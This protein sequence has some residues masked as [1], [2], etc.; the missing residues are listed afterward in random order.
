MY[1]DF[2]FNPL[3]VSIHLYIQLTE[4]SNIPAEELS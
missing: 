2:P 1:E 3:A 4:W